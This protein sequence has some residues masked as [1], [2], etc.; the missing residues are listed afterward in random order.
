MVEGVKWQ[1]TPEDARGG[2]FGEAFHFWSA[3]S[4]CVNVSTGTRP[5]ACGPEL[6]IIR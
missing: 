3:L 6:Q 4:V 1:D 2:P 5:C